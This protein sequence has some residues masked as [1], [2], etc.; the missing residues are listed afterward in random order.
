MCCFP[1]L[2]LSASLQRAM[3]GKPPFGWEPELGSRVGVMAR[4]AGI[5]TIRWF[6]TDPCYVFH[7]MNA[8]EEGDKIIADVMQY[9]NAPLFPERGRIAR[10]ARVGQ[11]G[12]LDIRSVGQ[13]ATRSNR[14]RSTTW[15]ANSRASTNAA[16]DFP[17]VTA[18]SPPTRAIRA[19]SMFNGIA[20]I[21]M[22][23]GKR[24]AAPVCR[25]AM[26]RANRSSCRAGRMRT[27]ATAG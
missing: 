15:R 27:K 18:I 5:E 17:T 24:L 9:P 4:N 23:T 10:Q 11:A 3:S 20:H 26:Y 21:D 22:Q 7:P 12:A 25:T 2:P 19:K 13:F 14:R 6:N 8:W 16:P 1:I